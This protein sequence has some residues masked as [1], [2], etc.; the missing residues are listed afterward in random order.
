ML[1][2]YANKMFII[3]REQEGCYILLL[4]LHYKQATGKQGTHTE[5]FSGLDFPINT[6]K[7]IHTYIHVYT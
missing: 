6:A 3:K 7:T 5:Q 1:C 2:S 4:L